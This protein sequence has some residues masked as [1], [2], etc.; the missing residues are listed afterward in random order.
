MIITQKHNHILEKAE[1][2]FAIKG[3]D[4]TTVR[5]IAE[6][7]GVNLAMISYYF[8]SKEKLLEALFKNRMSATKARLEDI[9][10][11][12]SLSLVQKIDI[13]IDEYIGRVMQKQSFYKIMLLEQVINKNYEVVKL[14]K[15]FKFSYA[16]LIS[17]LI[18]EGQK[19]KKIKK[20]ID[21]IMLLTTMT[22]TVTQMI[23]N[24]D[25]YREFNEYKKLPD[26]A[27][28]TILKDNLSTHIKK[29]FKATL[30]YE[31]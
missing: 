3:Y 2:L 27:F 26:A 19:A 23:V 4:G 6:E 24:K 18:A 7:A 5:D 16:K 30:G 20:N 17:S 15:E 1:V 28:E 13:L 25:Y 8:G 31:E 12:Q 29:I 22:G 9:I 10:S 14:L 11:N 21:V